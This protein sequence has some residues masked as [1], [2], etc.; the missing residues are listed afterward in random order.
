MSTATIVSLMPCDIRE[1]K[2]SIMPAEY[3][4]PAAKPP[5]FNIIVIHDGQ[6]HLYLDQDRGTV[7]VPIDAHKLA[8]SIVK[9]YMYSCI[10]LDY[11]GQATPGLFWV[12]GELTKELIKKDHL[13]KLTEMIDVQNRW[14]MRLVK[15][16][17]DDWSRNQQHRS[18][19]S[20]QRSAATVLK[21]QIG[22]RPW[23]VEVRDMVQFKTCK[24]CT[25][26]INAAALVC[27]ICGRALV[28]E[29]EL[30]KATA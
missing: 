9:D 16:A 13:K 6:G 2:P 5:D 17:D 23:N 3:F 25:S 1:S 26:T 30:K 28:S 15:T 14:F 29:D 8:D 24:F 21:S 20:I 18:I 12:D 27:P 7:A 10:D 11:L 19:T 4:I 22:E